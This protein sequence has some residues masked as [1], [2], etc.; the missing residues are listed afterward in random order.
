M[1]LIPFNND[2]RQWAM[3]LSQGMNNMKVYP[4]INEDADLQNRVVNGWQALKGA[5]LRSSKQ[6]SAKKHFK[7][8]NKTPNLITISAPRR[9]AVPLGK[10]RKMRRKL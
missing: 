4:D 8:V 7:D 5:C 9:L 2:L 10:K 3:D 6:A 1:G